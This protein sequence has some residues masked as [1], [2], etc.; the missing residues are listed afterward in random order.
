MKTI[1]I[2]QNSYISF[3]VDAL[4]IYQPTQYKLVLII[5]EFGAAI[6]KNKHQ[7]TYYEQIIITNDFHL[8]NILAIIRDQVT[9]SQGYSV[10]TNSEETMPICGEVRLNLGLDSQD[11]SRFYDKNSMK[12][13][14][15]KAESPHYFIPKYRLFDADA[16]K[17]SKDDY[18]ANLLSHLSFP[19]FI[20]PTQLYS[21]IHL[22]KIH[23]AIEFHQWAAVDRGDE[24][25]EIDEFIDGT[26][27]HC[28]SYLKNNAIVF[29]LVCQNSRPCYD[30]TLGEIKGTIA[31]PST[32][33]DTVL[34]SSITQDILM[35]LGMPAAGVTHLEVIKTTDH[36]VYFIE[37]AYRAPGCLIP[38]M[39]QTHANLDP[40]SAHY[41]LQM[42]ADF[43]PT[44]EIK[45]YAAWACYPKIPGQVKVLHNIPDTITSH[46]EL[47]WCVQLGDIL[48]TLPQFGRDYTGTLFMTHDDFETLHQEF[49]QLAQQNLCI[50]QP[51]T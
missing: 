26:M 44:P 33:P 2:L 23:N 27:Y 16:Y 35:D 28:D 39:H 3:D 41:L 36:K 22:Q 42:D 37:I 13:Q 40:I 21:S 32:H 15:E 12:A 49:L 50:I 43:Q 19:L 20:K 47:N 6:V 45:T 4:K 38:K 11:Y 8:N 51:D 9:P 34:L 17:H 30:F 14:L 29:T 46:C 1:I 10:I 5:N 7:E 24:H 18:L 25:F 48:T 31:L